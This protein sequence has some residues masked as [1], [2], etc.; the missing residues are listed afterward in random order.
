MAK[1][2]ALS[3][4]RTRVREEANMEGSGFISDAELNRK[5]NRS[6]ES[7]YDLLIRAHGDEYYNSSDS[8]TLVSGTN[9]YALPATFYKLTAATF[10]VNGTRE[11]PL[12]KMTADQASNINYSSLPS[13]TVK[14]YFAPAFVDLSADG[15]TFD[16]ING[17]EEWAVLDAAIKCLDKEET[18][19]TS[20]M[21]R[22]Q[23][24]EDRLDQM[25]QDRDL[26]QNDRIKD[27]R[28]NHGYYQSMG[29]RIR[30]SNIVF[31]QLS[32]DFARFY[33]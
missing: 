8:V 2:V 20:R 22:M 16:G 14:L 1:T 4:L 5:I 30:G 12:K 13:G 17:F 15:D 32:G 24:I 25:A 7:L 27:V 29:Y 6:L 18:D 3:V 19:I 28:R 31:G 9:S 26:S 33:A 10:V 21:I 23:K 11:I